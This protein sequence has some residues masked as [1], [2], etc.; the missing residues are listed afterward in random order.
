[1]VK[2]LLDIGSTPFNRDRDEIASWIET[3]ERT[4]PTDCY[5]SR[6]EH[7]HLPYDRQWSTF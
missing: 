2:V 4:T 6:E 7:H 5:L 1:M 3:E